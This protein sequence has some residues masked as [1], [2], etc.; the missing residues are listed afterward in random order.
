ME[1]A[2]EFLNKNNINKSNITTI[3]LIFA[4]CV[5][6]YLIIFDKSDYAEANKVLNEKNEQLMR[7][8][9][10]LKNEEIALYKEINNLQ[11][12]IDA[13]SEADSL[14]TVELE[15]EKKLTEEERRK[16]MGALKERELALKKLE[17]FKKNPNIPS[18]PD[19]LILDT[20]KRIK[21]R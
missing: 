6:G 2:K 9:T 21:Q 15:K 1:K 7:E 8:K 16:R 17:E 4:I 18:D 13:L 11:N 5:I 14:K 3:L 10:K 20:K 19:D 12:E